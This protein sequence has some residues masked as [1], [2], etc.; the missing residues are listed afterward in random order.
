MKYI[1]LLRSAYLG[2]FHR[3][4]V[5]SLA[6]LA[7]LIIST[8]VPQG[9]DRM[10]HIHRNIEKAPNFAKLKEHIGPKV[11]GISLKYVECQALH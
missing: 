10:N 11:G 2:L 4:T 1:L 7:I 9:L 5:S 3:P 6:G 8:E